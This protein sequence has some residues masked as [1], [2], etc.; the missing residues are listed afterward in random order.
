MLTEGSFMVFSKRYGK[1]E[2]WLRFQ[3]KQNA[4]T[5]RI[6]R[7]HSLYPKASLDRLRGH[8]KLK[9]RALRQAVPVPLHKRLW[10]LLT[11]KEKVTRE[12]SL[13]VLSLARRNGTRLSQLA[14][15]HKISINTVLRNTNAF[16][17][18]N[19]RWI[20]KK[21]DRISRVLLINENGK[22]IFVEVNDSRQASLIGKCHS[23]V[24]KYLE[25][26][27]REALTEFKGKMIRDSSGKWHTLETNPSAIRE[28]NARREEP[29]FYDIYQVSI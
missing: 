23:A 6:A 11:P 24:R 8:A 5:R 13:E 20:P 12:R 29:E 21:S 25:N 22:E 7:L 28:I 16:K 3:P 17:R 26:G 9:T 10:S 19:G 18:I 1:F 2:N 27:N 15:E 14:E 4:Y